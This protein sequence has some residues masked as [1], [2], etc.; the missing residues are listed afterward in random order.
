MIRDRSSGNPPKLQPRLITRKFTLKPGFLILLLEVSPRDSSSRVFLSGD[1]VIQLLFHRGSPLLMELARSQRSDVWFPIALRSHC[2]QLAELSLRASLLCLASLLLVKCPL[3]R[4]E[5]LEKP[6]RVA[7]RRELGVE[8][9]LRWRAGLAIW[10][11][12]PMS[13]AGVISFPQAMKLPPVKWLYLV[14]WPRLGWL[15]CR[16]LPLRLLSRPLLS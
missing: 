13:Q 12:K 15:L 4:R 5:F 16:L 3:L 1:A 7:S 9:F 6:F 2:G 8:S 10:P 11:A 14:K